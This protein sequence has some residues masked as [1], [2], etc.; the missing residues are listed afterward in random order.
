ML[1]AAQQL[2]FRTNVKAQGGAIATAYTAK[3]TDAI[4]AAYN[5]AAS[6]DFWIWRAAVTK[7]EYV[8]ST[9]VDSTTWSWTT[10]IGRSQGERDAWRELFANAG[11][12]VNPSLAQIRAA[13]TDI[14][15]GAGGLAQRTHVL[16][17]SRRKATLFSK[18]YAVGA[19]DT[20]T[21][22]V[23]PTA[24]IDYQLSSQ[25]AHDA[26]YDGNGNPI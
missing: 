11:Q 14:F 19:G 23:V 26:L 17:V 7:D 18:L 8:N 10:Y 22:G 1:T 16:T 21:P 12:T 13:F 9:S 24:L 6:P 4:A 3:D 5:V 25:D 20:T 15:S 2:T